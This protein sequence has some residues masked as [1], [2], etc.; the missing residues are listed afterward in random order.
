MIIVLFKEG[1]NSYQVK[2]FLNFGFI[3][4]LKSEFDIT[5]SRDFKFFKYSINFLIFKFLV[6]NLTHSQIKKS[7]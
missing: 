7:L 2:Y 1:K 3:I 6:L 5:S 4:I